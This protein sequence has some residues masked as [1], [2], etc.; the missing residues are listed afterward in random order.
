MTG[1]TGITKEAI[2]ALAKS[3]PKLEYVNFMHCSNV[4]DDAMCALARQ[5]PLLQY[6]NLRHTAVSNVTLFE[7]NE[8]C[9]NLVK[10][11]VDLP[12]YRA[13]PEELAAQVSWIKYA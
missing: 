6:I 10:V 4:N 5:C 7:L 12:L 13:R 3:C 9:P 2:E 11:V 1:L 8:H